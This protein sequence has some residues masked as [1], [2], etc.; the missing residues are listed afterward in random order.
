M[1]ADDWVLIGVIVAHFVAL[2]ALILVDPAGH[3]TQR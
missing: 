2:I 1:H 3:R